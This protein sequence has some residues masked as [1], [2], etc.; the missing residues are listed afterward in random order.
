MVNV[1]KKHNYINKYCAIK[2][3]S[4][5]KLSHKLKFSLNEERII[6]ITCVALVAFNVPELDL[7]GN[8]VAILKENV[9]FVNISTYEEN[10]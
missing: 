6:E 9:F 2:I 3:V 7:C 10:R 5:L 4:N 8:D 1:F